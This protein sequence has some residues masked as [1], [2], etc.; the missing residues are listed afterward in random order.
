MAKEWQAQRPQKRSHGLSHELPREQLRGTDIALRLVHDTEELLHEGLRWR[1]QQPASTRDGVPCHPLSNQAFHFDLGGAG[2]R[3]RWS[4]RQEVA[5]A[6]ISPDHVQQVMRALL[7]F[8]Q[9]Y[10]NAQG[11]WPFASS[12]ICGLRGALEQYRS[13]QMPPAHGNPLQVEVQ[14]KNH[15][16]YGGRL[17]SNG[18]PLQPQ[19]PRAAA[20]TASSYRINLGPR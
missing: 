3:A 18:S 9:E 14:S 13:T 4:M 19:T 16:Y 1:P 20:S 17:S 10:R 8:A 11:G 6:D 2:T 7:S 5:A 12:L 15:A